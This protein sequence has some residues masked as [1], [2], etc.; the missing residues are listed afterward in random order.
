MSKFNKTDYDNLRMLVKTIIDGEIIVHKE[1]IDIAAHT[2]IGHYRIFLLAEKVDENKYRINNFFES[3]SK[4][5]YAYEKDDNQKYLTSMFTVAFLMNDFY[6][7][8][9]VNY[10]LIIQ[11]YESMLDKNPNIFE[12]ANWDMLFALKGYDKQEKKSERLYNAI[13]MLNNWLVEKSPDFHNIHII[14]KYQIIKRKRALEKSE[15]KELISMLECT[16]IEAMAKVGINL[17]LENKSM[18]ELQFEE[19][20]PI[21]QKF[22][23]EQPIYHFM[24]I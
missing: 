21:E 3:E 18:A 11:S 6:R 24:T 4:M 2:D 12:R 14:N 23:M 5:Y 10:A 13:T 20:N 7:F 22:F 1:P 9:N 17:L 8:S 15:K 16:D 19:L